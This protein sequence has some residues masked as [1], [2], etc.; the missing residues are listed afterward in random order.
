MLSNR[1]RAKIIEKGSSVSEV[2]KAIGINP[3]TFW[4]KCN[5]VSSFT[6]KEILD[7]KEFLHLTVE[8]VMYIFFTD[9][10]T[11]TQEKEQLI[12]N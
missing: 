3:A 8:E 9:E 12:C 6:R 2:S 1:L 5:G 7:I 11:E 10:L 4:R